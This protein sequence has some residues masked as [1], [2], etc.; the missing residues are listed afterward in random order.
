MRPRPDG[1]PRRRVA[2]RADP[3]HH[4]DVRP[5]P[6]R[7]ASAC[8]VAALLAACASG[9]PPP[10]DSGA[11]PWHWPQGQG[12]PR[13]FEADRSRC[14]YDAATFRTSHPDLYRIEVSR[15]LAAYGWHRG[16][17]PGATTP[18]APAD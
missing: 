9:A 15:C 3:G 18:S 6:S 17:A 5:R 11:G 8:V 12:A 4:G 16:P 2:G 10:D 13:D 14:R 7:L 1:T